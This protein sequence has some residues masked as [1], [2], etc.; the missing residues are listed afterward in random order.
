MACSKFG[1]FLRILLPLSKPALAAVA[2]FSFQLHWNDFF[3]P[4]IYLFDK[5]SSRWRWTSSSSRATMAP[6]G[7]NLMAV[8]LVM[9][10]PVILV[11]FFAQRISIQGVVYQEFK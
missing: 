5:A 10:L 6:T 1:V 7:A 11:Y 9:M 3:Y 4:R 2:I 8:S